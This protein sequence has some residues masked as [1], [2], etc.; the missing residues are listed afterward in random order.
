MSPDA[1][2]RASVARNPQ[3][4]WCDTSQRGYLVLELTPDRATGEWRF[5]DT[6]RQKSTALAGIKRMTV[7]AKQR[8]FESS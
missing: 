7:L 4:K 8:R 1:L 6:V 5:I 2:A 3:L